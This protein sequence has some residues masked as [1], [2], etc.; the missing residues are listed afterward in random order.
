[1]FWQYL[2]NVSTVH[3]G[4]LPWLPAVLWPKREDPDIRALLK[5]YLTILENQDSVTSSPLGRCV[6]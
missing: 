3:H 4:G 6:L 1:M 5:A 2:C